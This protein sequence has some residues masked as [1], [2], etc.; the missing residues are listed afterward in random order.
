ME[1][2]RHVPPGL[3]FV[4]STVRMDPNYKRIA[5]SASVLAGINHACFCV[6]VD[7]CEEGWLCAVD[8]A[9]RLLDEPFFLALSG[10]LQCLIVS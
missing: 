8:G 4:G 9:S 6:F 1:V 5:A 2:H 7:V 3:A 10:A